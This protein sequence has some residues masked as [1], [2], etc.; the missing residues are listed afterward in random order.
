MNPDRFVVGADDERDI[1]VMRELCAP[2]DRSHDKLIVMDVRSA[3]LTKY[4]AN[5]MPATRIS[6]INELALLAEKLGADIEWV[7]HGIGSYR[8][9]GYY[10]PNA[11][12][13]YVGSCFPKEV[14]ASIKTAGEASEHLNVLHGVELANDAQK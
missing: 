3:E 5:A 4:A 9:I 11:G 13:G 7:R 14:K 2:F 10:F 12:R 8:R 1:K 6:F